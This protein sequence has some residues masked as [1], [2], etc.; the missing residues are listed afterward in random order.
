M[1][2]RTYTF[3]IDT[4]P[5]KTAA[6]ADYGVSLSVMHLDEQ[7]VHTDV[8]M[9]IT[10]WPEH[11]HIGFNFNRLSLAVE[12]LLSREPTQEEVIKCREQRKGQ[13]QDYCNDHLVIGEISHGTC[14]EIARAF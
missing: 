9:T 8:K 14:E 3:S 10:G 1:N 2:G 11:N 12:G 7:R 4:S 13:W 5:K 6:W